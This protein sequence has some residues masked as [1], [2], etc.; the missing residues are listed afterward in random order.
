LR[1]NRKILIRQPSG[2][3]L[4]L[5]FS[6]R[7]IYDLNFK[8]SGESYEKE[9]QFTPTGELISGTNFSGKKCLSG[10]SFHAI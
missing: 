7:Y 2:K 10:A 8:A 1:K 5:V 6:F 3:V 4:P 9:R